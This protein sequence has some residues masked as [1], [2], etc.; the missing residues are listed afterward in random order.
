[1]KQ[2]V[3]QKQIDGKVFVFDFLTHIQKKL[4]NPQNDFGI[5]TT[6][7]GKKIEILSK[8]DIDGIIFLYF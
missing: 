6:N 4:L 7:E 3:W 8:M 5:L 2:K 1:M